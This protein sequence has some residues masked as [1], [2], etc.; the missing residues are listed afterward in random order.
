MDI[1]QPIVSLSWSLTYDK[2]AIGTEEG[3]IFLVDPMK[4]QESGARLVT[5]HHYSDVVGID[6]LGFESDYCI[7]SDYNQYAWGDDSI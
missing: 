1:C 2:L 4:L 5:N 6:V 3:S 7:V